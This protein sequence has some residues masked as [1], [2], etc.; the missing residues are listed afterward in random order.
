M[1]GCVVDVFLFVLRNR[2]GFLFGGFGS[3]S[4]PGENRLTVFSDLMSTLTG[5]GVF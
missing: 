1:V 3:D 4:V 2:L 5:F